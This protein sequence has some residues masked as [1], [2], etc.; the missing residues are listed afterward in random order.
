MGKRVIMFVVFVL[1]FVS[2]FLVSSQSITGEI[3]TGE[4][5]N[6]VVGFN[7]TITGAPALTIV[8]PRNETYYNN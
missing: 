1:F 8:N 3:V 6:E 5:T 4:V 7:I 2:V